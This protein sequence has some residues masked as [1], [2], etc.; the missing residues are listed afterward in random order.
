MEQFLLHFKATCW[1][2]NGCS[3]L[4]MTFLVIQMQEQCQAWKDT[5]GSYLGF[6][7]DYNFCVSTA[8]ILLECNST[9]HLPLPFGLYFYFS[10]LF[11]S[12]SSSPVA[13]FDIHVFAYIQ[14][15]FP[16]LSNQVPWG[17]LL[18]HS[19]KFIMHHNFESYM[20]KSMLLEIKGEN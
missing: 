1:Y 19:F 13:P 6:G 5:F 4:S 11:I 9:Q 2:S 14:H 16:C 20:G 3:I 17:L 8:N 7:V 18:P 10:S 12:F 15:I